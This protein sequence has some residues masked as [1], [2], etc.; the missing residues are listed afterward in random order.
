MWLGGL[1]NYNGNWIH[2]LTKLSMRQ[3]GHWGQMAFWDLDWT[4]MKLNAQGSLWASRSSPSFYD[5]EDLTFPS[6]RLYN[7]L[8]WGSFFAKG[9]LFSSKSILAVIMSYSRPKPESDL[10]MLKQNTW[11]FSP[12]KKLLILQNKRRNWIICISRTLGN[13][14]E[15]GF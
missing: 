1:R 3:S 5:W 4:W 9:C 10:S 6:W 13:M 8:V 15:C 2:R 14:C 11:R 7:H 12:G